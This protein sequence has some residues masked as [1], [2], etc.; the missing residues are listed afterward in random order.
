MPKASLPN[1]SVRTVICRQL[2][3]RTLWHSRIPGKGR[4]GRTGDTG[5]CGI[6]SLEAAVFP[7]RVGYV[8][9]TNRTLCLQEPCTLCIPHN[10]DR[11]NFFVVLHVNN[12]AGIDEDLYRIVLRRPVVLYLNRPEM[13]SNRLCNTSIIIYILLVAVQLAWHLATSE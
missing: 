1:L 10:S 4:A 13:A 5:L 7:G 12:S 11:S 2:V 8:S 3:G 6:Q 9:V